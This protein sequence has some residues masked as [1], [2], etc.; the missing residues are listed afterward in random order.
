MRRVAVANQ[1]GGVG[2][3]T[4]VVNLGAA[5][6]ERGRRVLVLDLDPQANASTWLGTVD[7]R[8]LYEVFENG[9]PLEKAVRPTGIANLDLVPSS[10]WMTRAERNAASQAGAEMILRQAVDELP[11]DQW[12]VILMDCPPALGLLCYSAL[13]ACTEVLI[14]V[15]TRVMPLAGL[16]ALSQTIDTVKLRLNRRLR[17]GAV[18]ACQV[19]RRTSLSREV[20]ESLR[21]RFGEVV[22][23]TIIRESVRIAEA[24]GHRLPVTTYA[25]DSSA[26][27]DYRAAAAEFDARSAADGET[28]ANGRLQRAR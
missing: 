6:A 9:A 10:S 12:D 2:K 11:E 22:M 7:A 17:L 20:V 26:A 23:D 27:A 25:P 5:L 3:T 24:P 13:A 8:A 4:T 1:K 19:D 15:Q 14:P 21:E 18:L 28:Q 16:V